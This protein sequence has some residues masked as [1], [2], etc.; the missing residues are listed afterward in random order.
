MS[1]PIHR[2]SRQRL[3]ELTTHAA[4]VTLSYVGSVGSL[5]A[6]CLSPSSIITI[7]TDA[8][9]A[10]STVR[11]MP[12]P[13]VIAAS[14][15]PSDG[16]L[17]CLFSGTMDTSNNPF[18]TISQL[19]EDTM[20]VTPHCTDLIFPSANSVLQPIALHSLPRGAFR[21]IMENGSVFL[22]KDTS[23]ITQQREGSPGEVVLSSTSTLLV[24]SWGVH[25]LFENSVVSHELPA[26]T[27]AVLGTVTS[28][29]DV[30]VYV[31][32]GHNVY[33]I[34]VPLGLEETG[35]LAWDKTS[36]I[37]TGRSQVCNVSAI[38]PYSSVRRIVI[39]FTDGTIQVSCTRY[40]GL[41]VASV[42]LP[43]LLTCV[44]HHESGGLLAL[45]Q[46][47]TGG[48]ALDSVRLEAPPRATSLAEL[49]RAK[50]PPPAMTAEPSEPESLSQAYRKVLLA[51]QSDT[52]K[53]PAALLELETALRRYVLL[54]P[55]Q[56]VNPSPPELEGARTLV[57]LLAKELRAS[58]RLVAAVGALPPPGVAKVIRR[59]ID[60]SDLTPAP[61]RP[62]IFSE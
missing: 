12:V 30:A 47:T 23:V 20:V 51:V 45:M 34:H 8:E 17:Y 41:V 27:G 28:A 19:L 22:V 15:S 40:N 31:S 21:V 18:Y 56:Q 37:G 43:G 49:L 3:Q 29:G 55:E 44:P 61:L 53:I 54:P 50:Q 13:G 48:F 42:V 39:A 9:R 5:T 32:E 25:H 57:T 33:S 26:T 14:I 58:Q 2:I 60:S 6:L 16:A 10:L 59:H 24:T 11:E 52:M 46:T 1:S 36:L 4:P 7:S 35:D 38:S 62:V